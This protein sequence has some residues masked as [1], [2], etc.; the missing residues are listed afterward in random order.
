MGGGLA[1]GA[2]RLAA[3]SGGHWNRQRRVRVE[4]CVRNVRAESPGG[5]FECEQ[6]GSISIS[7]SGP[8]SYL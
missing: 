4:V 7:G 1:I 3:V 2:P 8:L 6:R 5:A